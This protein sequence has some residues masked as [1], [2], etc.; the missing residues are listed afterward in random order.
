[1]GIIRPN[2]VFVADLTCL[3]TLEGFC[4][5]ALIIDAYS[6]KVVGYD[7]STSLVGHRR[8]AKER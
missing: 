4:Y 2:Q 7:L 6:H 1:M 5:L 3:K 8:G